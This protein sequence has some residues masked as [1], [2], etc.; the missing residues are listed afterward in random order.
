[1]DNF[2][3]QYSR[4]IESGAVTVGR[5]VRL[6]YEYIEKGLDNKLFFYSLVAL[7]IT[8]VSLLQLR[9]SHVNTGAVFAVHVRAISRD[10]GREQGLAVLPCHYKQDLRELSD[11]VFINDTKQDR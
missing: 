10:R 7:I 8:N 4:S 1:M 5:W 2:I 9:G 6:L 11:A 3:H